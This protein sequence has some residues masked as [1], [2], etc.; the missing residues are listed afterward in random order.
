[1][2]RSLRVDAVVVGA[3]LAGLACA[4][5]L[6][7]T[8]LNVMLLESAQRPGGRM[9]SDR[10]GDFVLDRGFQVFNTSYPQVKR[11]LDLRAL[12]LR[13][14]EPGFVLARGDQR[15]E[16]ADPTRRPEALTSLLR[17]GSAHDVAALGALSARDMLTPTRLLKRGPDVTARE[18]LRNAGLSNRF[19]ETLLVP[20]LRGVF[21]DQ[22]LTV[23]GRFFHLVWRSML[24]GTLCLPERGVGQV[25]R[26]LADRLPMG[27]LRLGAPVERVDED[28]VRLTGGFLV[29]A[30]VVVVATGATAARALLPNLPYV[31]TRAVTTVYH[32]APHVPWPGK[33]LLVD[34]DGR[35]LHTCV[36]SNAQPA[37]APCGAALV[38]T[39]LVGSATPEQ[40]QDAERRL[41]ELYRTSTRSWERIAVQHVR[42]ALPALPAS[43]PLIR[44]TRVAPGRYVCGD[45]RATASVQGALASGARA[46]REVIDDLA[47][48]A[49]R[50]G[51]LSTAWSP[52][53]GA[54]VRP[55]PAEPLRRPR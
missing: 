29:Q 22:D 30:P 52:R 40:I 35:L 17:A 15:V 4:S 24:R 34:G 55:L 42:E 39:S 27:V 46:A 53:F 9:V 20:F 44:T 50:A 49:R 21:L 19:A 43:Q 6:C 7:D 32:A 33:Q 48:P 12:R 47:V 5:D 8:G 54:P 16:V 45:H 38:S 41:P 25:P 3:G 28:G 14:F 31:P 37:Y 51:G 36:V 1:V 23:S 11:R 18:A 13:A 2:S 10:H 26:Q